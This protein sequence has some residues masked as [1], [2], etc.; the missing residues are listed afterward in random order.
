[1]LSKLKNWLKINNNL[2]WV[3]VV[4]LMVIG[5]IAMYFIAPYTITRFGRNI[6][7]NRYWQIV[8]M[9]FLVML[10]CSR[11]SKKIVL[12]TSWI[13]GIISLLLI[14]MTAI[15]P[16][17]VAGSSRFI[18]LF[19]GIIDPF[20]V[21]LPA[22]IVILSK[23]LS[24][25][26]N[27]L[28]IWIGFVI[29]L[30]ISTVA[31]MAPYMFMAELYLLVFGIMAFA[32]HRIKPNVFYA[33]LGGALCMFIMACLFLPHVQYR[34]VNFGNYATQMSLNAITHSAFIGNT[35]QSLSA[36]SRLPGSINDF[37][38]TS[39]IAKF[40]LLFGLLV[41]GLYGCIAIKLSD[42]I[43][44]STEKF[45]KNITI[46]TLTLF[47]TCLVVS[48][49][50]AFGLVSVSASWPF[51]GLYGSMYMMWCMLFG[52]VFAVNKNK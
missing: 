18:H 6:V 8:L 52:F 51:L 11:L 4:G 27:K 17:Y 40:G 48:F 5:V 12:T 42:I 14:L 7:F 50:M 22:Y 20:A 29:T 21:M 41:L 26:N 45:D 43:K 46:G 44:T 47:T 39:I 35:T 25:E 15:S 9:G 24:D 32:S 19:G 49:A 31:C 34:L 16:Y 33:G 36:L 3:S 13:I 37:M 23:W 30:F 1:M 38:F 28:G 10:L 2:L